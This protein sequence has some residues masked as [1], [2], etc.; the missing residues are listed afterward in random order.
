MILAAAGDETGTTTINVHGDLVG[1]SLL[2]EY[3]AGVNGTPRIVP[4]ITVDSLG[5]S[6]PC[7]L[8]VDVQGAEHRVLDGATA[9][10]EHA[11]M[12]VL[13]SSLFNFFDGGLLLHELIAYMAER[14]FLMYDIGEM[15]RRP[16]D[17]ALSQVDLVFVPE[18]SQVRAHNVYAT[19]AQRAA[20]NARFAA[21]RT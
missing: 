18:R 9:T 4:M 15:H 7:L 20:Q 14:R 13:E 17:G 11:E 8:K 1:S 10:L 6:E 12:V 21:R 16:L 19:P 5:V 3:E 2:D